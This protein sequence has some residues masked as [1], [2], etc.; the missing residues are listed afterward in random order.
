MAGA[1]LVEGLG[2]GLVSIGF[3]A[4]TD[5]LAALLVGLDSF[6]GLPSAWAVVP[7]WLDGE[8]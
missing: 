2:A 6:I 7:P 8:V 5:V 3:V 1:G 4:V